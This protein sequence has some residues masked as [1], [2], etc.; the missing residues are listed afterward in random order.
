MEM[1]ECIFSTVATDALVQ[2]HLTNH[3]VDYIYITLDQFHKEIL[4][5][6]GKI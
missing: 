1:Y 3:S 6:Y 4:Y 5:S 2:K